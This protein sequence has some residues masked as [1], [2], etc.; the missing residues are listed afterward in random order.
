MTPARDPK[1]VLR[2]RTQ[3]PRP[4]TGKSTVSAIFSQVFG[5]GTGPKRSEMAVGF[6]WVDSRGLATVLDPFRA[7]FADLGRTAYLGLEHC[8]IWT[9]ETSETSTLCV[10]TRQ[11]SVLAAEGI[12]PVSTA[13]ICP[14]STED[15]TAAGSCSVFSSDG[16]DVFC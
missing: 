13:D 9:V 10:E 4:G 6:I 2:S 14:A 1:Q 5:R 15:G 3:G 7:I 16:I 8:D 12:C 11:M